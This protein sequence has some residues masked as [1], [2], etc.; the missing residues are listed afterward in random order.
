M[1]FGLTNALATF[2]SCMNHIFKAQLRK[3]LLVF[4]DDILICSI[5][6]EKH[7]RH[8]D[9]VLGI[10]QE[11]SLYAKISKCEFIMQE[12]LYL[13]HVIGANGVQVHLENI[14]EIVDWPTPKN[15]IELKGF[16]GICTYYRRYVSGFS[17]MT[18]PLTDLT[19][20]GA[21]NWSKT[22]RQTFEKMKKVMSSCPILALLDFSQPFILECD[23]SAEG[24][25]V[26]LMQKKHPVAF[27]RKKLKDYEC[28]Y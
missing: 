18:A 25:G 6:W 17:Q 28:H 9:E 26:V 7:L 23:A 3:Y 24:I 22:S 11:Q 27:E 12:M 16:L 15:V 1:P 19:K 14:W 10:L 8:L 20:K 5:T 21:F 4:F 13:G 2:Q